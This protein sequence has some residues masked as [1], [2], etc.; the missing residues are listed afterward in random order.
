MKEIFFSFLLSNGSIFGIAKG[1]NKRAKR[2]E[3]AK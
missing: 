2:Q 1:T 3:K